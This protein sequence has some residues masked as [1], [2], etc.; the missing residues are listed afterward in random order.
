MRVGVVSLG[1]A[2]NRVDTEQMLFILG[3]AG[4]SFTQDMGDAE[5]LIVNTCGFIQPAKEESIDAILEMA[6]YKGS[7][8]CR[9]LCVTGCLSQRYGAELMEEIPEID[10][11]AGVSAYDRLPR[12]LG[13][14]L[15]QGTRVLDT[16]RRE[17]FLDCGRILTT[18]AYSVYVKI[19]EG[20][21]NRCAYC[22]IPLI[23]GP[24]RSR[25]LEDILGEVR[26]LARQGVKEQILIAQDTTRFSS[27]DGGGLAALLHEA[28]SVPGVDWLRVLYCYPD[29]TD[30]A[31]IDE[32][33]RHGNICRYLDLPLQHASAR[34]LAA[35]RRRCDLEKV[36]RL[37]AYARGKGFALRTTFMVGFPGETEE[38]FDELLRFA[39]E[40]RFDRMGAFAFSPEED[41]AAA[42]MPGQVSEAA[43]QRRLGR[44]MLLQKRISRERGRERI[45]ARCRVLVTGR[46]GGLYLGR[47]EWEAP[48]A[49][50]LI[51]FSSDE[52]FQPG[53]F[54]L[55]SLTGADDYDLTGEAVPGTD[56]RA[57]AAD[58]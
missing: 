4:Y 5:I 25:P 42:T 31:L 50:G 27:G 26:T 17:S 41:T 11:L 45:G 33:A 8:A 37:L 24:Y 3:K 58:A 51:R 15:S 57:R 30:E 44:L 56:P 23:R 34:V 7:G 48:D 43:K 55:V 1:C 22:A 46:E 12:M 10:V 6:A 16:G 13:V 14:A 39:G 54:V 47:S 20:C 28:A 38:D 2:K 18:P 49:D 29:E 32:M 9:L 19:S 36:K 52:G 53:D 40:M 35:M 21:D